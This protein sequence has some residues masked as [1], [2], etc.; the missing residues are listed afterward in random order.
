[1]GPERDGR[2]TLDFEDF[3]GQRLSLINDAGA[4]VGHSWDRERDP[5]RTS[6]PR[7]RADHHQCARPAEDR[8]GV[9]TAVLGM[10]QIR[11]YATPITKGSGT[12]VYAMDNGGPAA[13]LMSLSSRTSL[14]RSLVPVASTT[15]LS[16]SPTLRFSL[17]LASAR[18]GHPVERPRRPLLFP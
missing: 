16:A 4:G 11:D 15:L 7:A 2:M 17:G 9:L 5:G 1:M 14:S 6:S 18:H 10:R 12:Y 3:E 8:P 13:E